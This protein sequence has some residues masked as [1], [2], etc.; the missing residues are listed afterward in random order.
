MRQVKIVGT[1]QFPLSLPFLWCVFVCA[2][3]R[4]RE[5]E[6]KKEMVNL[7]F[8][9]LM[10]STAHGLS[11]QSTSLVTSRWSKLNLHTCK[12]SCIFFVFQTAYL[13]CII[14][15]C[16][17]NILYQ[18]NLCMLCAISSVFQKAFVHCVQNLFLFTGKFG[19]KNDLIFKSQLA[20]HTV[21]L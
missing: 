17:I 4:E 7:I 15:T 2:T 11:P 8:S 16:V 14:G 10:K 6:R 5:R 3:E 1:Y 20:D 9:D 18:S 21:Y 12:R 13:S 19:D